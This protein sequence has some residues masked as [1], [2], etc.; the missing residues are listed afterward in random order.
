VTG[1]TG[2]PAIIE[3]LRATGEAQGWDAIAQAEH[4][5]NAPGVRPETRSAAAQ[6]LEQLRQR[7]ASFLRTYVLGAR[8]ALASGE[9]ATAA[10]LA[11]MALALNPAH[12]VARGLQALA[13]RDSTGVAPAD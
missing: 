8:L 4:A 12:D 10:S 2:A 6:A 11:D 5:L 13:R 9:P 7:D 1:G 3:Q